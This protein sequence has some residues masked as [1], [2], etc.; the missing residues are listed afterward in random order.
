MHA[1][2]ITIGDEI[3]YGQII[4]T[5]SQWM[6]EALDEIGVRTIRKTTVGD[7]EKAIIAAFQ[8]AFTRVDLVFI[9]GGLGPTH[10]DITKKALAAYFDCAISINPQALEEIRV[11][12][13]KRGFILS[14][15]NKQQAALP[16][17]CEMI[18]NKNGM[19]CSRALAPVRATTRRTPAETDSSLRISKSSTS[20]VFSKCVPPH[21]SRL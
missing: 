14:E 15:T 10:D 4:D 7:D 18:S 19:A 11:L 3:L 20:P 6:S 1:E 2:I 21:S 5:N 16:E 13:E 8:E 12:F 17:R 9:T